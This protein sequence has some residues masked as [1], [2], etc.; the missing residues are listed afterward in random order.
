MSA[1]IRT[2]QILIGVS[3]PALLLGATQGWAAAPRHTAAP[4]TPA[5]QTAALPA[6]LTSQSCDDLDPASLVQAIET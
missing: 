1:L 5:R 4:S 3:L 2:W 6:E